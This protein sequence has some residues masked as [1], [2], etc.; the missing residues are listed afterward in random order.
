VSHELTVRVLDCRA[1]YEI[2]EGEGSCIPDPAGGVRP[3]RFA[4]SFATPMDT[5][6]KSVSRKHPSEGL[7]PVLGFVA[8]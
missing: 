3:G 8:F 6:L 5:Y 1:A 4:A 2:L 7:S